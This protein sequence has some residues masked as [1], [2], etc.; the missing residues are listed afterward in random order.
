MTYQVGVDLGTTFTAAAICR[1]GNGP[2]EI[3]PLG[4]RARSVPSIGYL[5][6]DGAL[7][8]GEVAERRAL[9]DP[10]RVV[11]EFK[12]RIGDPTPMLVGRDRITA[13]TLTARFLSRVLQDV[14]A[15]EGGPASRIAVTHP[16]GWGQHKLRSLRTALA[17]NG[18]GSAAF[19]AEPQAAAI[20]YAHAERIEPAPP[21]EHRRAGGKA[22]G[23]V[24]QDQSH[25]RDAA[26]RAIGPGAGAGHQAPTA[27]SGSSRGTAEGAGA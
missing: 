11:R 1:P 27:G 15:R 9:S 16:A 6:A 13:E 8:I 20:G 5:G 4:Q 18:L 22:D 2:A 23:R 10:A 14:A 25:G 24:E 19:V 12:R 3:V 26:G 7:Q 17:E 21:G